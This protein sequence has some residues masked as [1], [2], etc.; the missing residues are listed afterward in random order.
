MLFLKPLCFASYSP[1]YSGRGTQ[2]C[3]IFSSCSLTRQLLRQDGQQTERCGKGCPGLGAATQLWYWMGHVSFP[4]IGDLLP[5]AAAATPAYS[6]FALAT[7]RSNC[8]INLG[9]ST[10]W[11]SMPVS[12]SFPMNCKMDSTLLLTNV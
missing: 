6:H 9:R 12:S 7:S 3:S 2:L 1:N 8:G 4:F 10:Y 11:Y 5:K